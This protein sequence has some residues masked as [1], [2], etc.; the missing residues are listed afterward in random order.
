MRQ[1]RSTK[2]LSLLLSLTMVLGMFTGT[3]A[4]A[5]GD[6]ET[7]TYVLHPYGLKSGMEVTVPVGEE[8]VVSWEW[9]Q[10]ENGYIPYINDVR[11]NADRTFDAE[12][13]API[14]CG[15]VS[16]GLQKIRSVP[17][18]D[19][20]VLAPTAETTDEELDI[21]VETNSP[22]VP[23][24]IKYVDQ[25]GVE[26]ASVDKVATLFDS[27]YNVRASLKDIGEL[28]NVD[29][30]ELVKP[31][32][33]SINVTKD[34]DGNNV[35]IPDVVT[36]EVNV[37]RL[38]A[39]MDITIHYMD[40]Q[41]EVGT[42]TVTLE[43]G[44][45]ERTILPENLPDNYELSP[46]DQSAT[47]EYTADGKV[48]IN[49]AVV[50]AATASITFTVKKA[51]PPKAYYDIVVNGEK[52][53]T[54]GVG[55]GTSA[56]LQW[57]KY[58]PPHIDGQ[59]D[60]E[61]FN[62]LELVTA[63][64]TYYPTKLTELDGTVTNGF[65]F[66]E[67]VLR[68]Q[69]IDVTG[70]YNM[71]EEA[72]QVNLDLVINPM[73]V[74]LTAAE[75]DA[76]K[77]P[78]SAPK[79]IQ[80]QIAEDGTPQGS[81]TEE[82]P[83]LITTAAELDA[84]RDYSSTYSPKYFKIV[85]DID[86]SGYAE[87][88]TPIGENR[89]FRFGGIVDGNGKTI[90]GLNVDTGEEQYAGLFGYIDNA[91]ITNLTVEVEQVR[92][93]GYVGGLVG[94]A[95]DST[96]TGCG[97]RAASDDSIVAGTSSATGG[98]VGTAL[99]VTIKNSYT[100]VAVQGSTLV[101]GLV[102]SYSGDTSSYVENCYATGNIASTNTNPNTHIHVGGLIGNAQ[103][104]DIRNC[105]TTGDIQAT[106]IRIGGLTGTLASTSTSK[107]I[108]NSYAAG[109]ITAGEGSSFVGG[110]VGS[111]QTNGTLQNTYYN[112][113][114]GIAGCGTVSSDLEDTSAGKTEAELKSIAFALELDANTESKSSWAKWG[115]DSEI[116]GGYPVLCGIGIG[117][118]VEEVEEAPVVTGVTITHPNA[119]IEKGTTELFTATVE[120]EN[121]SQNVTWS[122]RG[123]NVSTIDA[124]GLL[125]V[126]ESEPYDIF[127]VRATSVDDPTKYAEVEVQLVPAGM[128]EG[129]GTEEDPYLITT[130]KELNAMRELSD[131]YRPKYFKIANDI[132]LSDYAETW[133]SIG[134]Y[135]REFGGIVDGNGKTIRG[136]K[137]DEADE[138]YVGLFAYLKNAVIK[139][140]TVE[141]EQVN[142]RVY[143][144]ALA[145]YANNTVID[146]C[147]VRAAS[148]ESS[149][150]GSSNVG[151]LVGTALRTTIT[152]SYAE[153]AVQGSTLVAGLVGSYSGDTSHYVENCYATG[154]VT[155]TNTDVDTHIHVGGLI[156]NAQKADI[157]NCF[158]AGNIQAT[159]KR[160][161]GL[162]GTL[163]G[164]SS[165]KGIKN[166][167]AAGTITAGEGSTWVGGLVGSFQTNGVLQDTYYNSD[168]GI[169]GCG[170]ASSK[171]EDTSTGKTGSELKSAAFALELDANTESNS[172]WAKWGLD[173]EINNGNPVLCG[174][175]IGKDVE[176]VEEMPVVTKITITHPNA[177]VEKGTTEPFTATVEGEN[178]SQNVTWSV[179]GSNVSTIDENGI[180][181]VPENEPNDILKVRATSVDD[182]TKY[183]EVEVQLVSAGMPEGS[184]TEA[185]PYLITTAKELDTMRKLSDTRSPKYFKIVNDIDVSDY[186]DT[187]TPIGNSSQEF[188]GIVDGNGK[189][190]RGLRVD[191]ADEMYVGLFA[192][193]RNSVIKNLTVE[194]EQ[195]N[196]RVDVGG[197]AGYAN[198]T[199]IDNCGVR[200]ASSES[201]IMGTSRVG[202]LVG[203]ASET[204][205][206]NSYAEVAVQGSTLV[207]GLVGSYSG[208]TSTYVE[209]CYATGDV[210]STNT[211]QKTH[212]EVGGLIGNAQKAD[213]RN[214]FATGDIQATGIRIGGLAGTF[215]GAD[216]DSGIKNSYAAGTITAG[217]GS[218]W[219]GG[220]VGSFQSKGTLQNAYYNS[221]NGLAG[222][223]AVFNN[224]ED[225]ST[226]KTEAE[227]KSDAFALELDTNTEPHSS[228]AKWG[229]D[230][231]IN[232]GYPVL[233]GIGIGA[234]VEEVEDEQ[235]VTF[236]SAG[237]GYL[238]DLTNMQTPVIET[239]A[240]GSEVPVPTTRPAN[241]YAF[242]HWTNSAGDRV[243]LGETVTVPFG[244]ETYT[245]HFEKYQYTRRFEITDPKYGTLTNKG[246]TGGAT[247]TQIDPQTVEV[248]GY[249]YSTGYY[250][251]VNV[252]DGYV[253]SGW[254]DKND[255]DGKIYKWTGTFKCNKDA[256]YEAVIVPKTTIQIEYQFVAEG[257]EKPIL[258]YSGKLT[259]NQ[260]KVLVSDRTIERLAEKGYRLDP[261]EQAEWEAL[262][263]DVGNITLGGKPV[264]WQGENTLITFTVVPNLPEGPQDISVS[265]GKNVKLTVDGESQLIADL[266]GK[267]QV[268]DVESGT[269][270][271]LTFTPKTKG[272]TFSSVKI[273]DAEP[274][275]ISGTT[276]TYEIKTPVAEADLSFTFEM[277]DKA[278]LQQA[279]DY[280]TT[281]VE[282]GT[283][284][285]LD[286][287]VRAAFMEAYQGAK[288]VL[289]NAKASQDDINEAWSELLDMIHYLG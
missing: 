275:Y 224:R 206:T 98:L 243:E 72:R 55:E 141:V 164:A 287:S 118:D 67:V 266:L 154:D 281:Y 83:Y 195:V 13:I 183:A 132:D 134:N 139:N 187:W 5:A 33:Q 261:A 262:Y 50:P 136:L 59:P 199:V 32:S 114:N 175:G 207:A 166:S 283:V 193:L 259:L 121:V 148:S 167:Y 16:G 2:I 36:F 54:L 109:T 233:C 159:G 285:Q 171:L 201:S 111:F 191:E 64:G 69:N 40:G 130:A 95:K 127:R 77:Y 24:T 82:D 106:G 9:D 4:F 289:D 68:A 58:T 239:G 112:S 61:P 17:A 231:E 18:E 133:T 189:T 192:Y 228:W 27:A 35:A 147:G 113:G 284:D 1:R 78:A 203:T 255:P 215:A 238:N 26:V 22:D 96:I 101:G 89:T 263:S 122:V 65:K 235:T 227:L 45:P 190:I 179:Q 277:T 124:D 60:K 223:G 211:E 8:A 200:A 88:W 185:D 144:G 126:P 174:I 226:G 150:V 123:S 249:D 219:V 240:V 245:A 163:A 76:E 252:A 62:R 181:T 278:I 57:K 43:K 85:N 138:M 90:R 216:T 212:V 102:G 129:S 209:N 237:G 14:E 81:G 177:K 31:T 25:D 3:T 30:I 23:Y 73:S 149:I 196:G 79:Q 173:E 274:V 46:A 15:K 204:T 202:G 87:T 198:D 244:G 250:P 194:V 180:L 254:R 119:K 264:E 217:E 247:S 246:G 269:V 75:G 253:W 268:K 286:E 93:K 145:G 66:N 242:S 37:V 115:L 42:D 19:A 221:G 165:S 155:S 178:V 170:S 52:A 186:A 116:N 156:G 160:I 282:D 38:E 152:N 103:K 63:K 143:V 120:G 128:P 131:T 230:A 29:D 21:L 142:G 34:E 51:A 125:T 273:G 49:G 257:V 28:E 105:F 218:T 20:Y 12:A 220:L 182:P 53:F 260:P 280:A 236:K 213:I 222:C 229:R 176:E 251:T 84:M 11:M 80:I 99:Y 270:I 39:T 117:E 44:A 108:K 157:R 272:Q 258:K 92:G 267:Y 107:G 256:T 158:A 104:A 91:T 205:I 248:M 225:T 10:E 140:L 184:G 6:G 151:G 146:N 288:D 74:D 47:A 265:Y 135:N 71:P 188:G 48:K 86:L 100:E 56:T 161:G 70:A 110:L 137:V 232:D 210:T 276:Y 234:D 41:T 271:T 241:G 172:S 97:V 94:Y 197:L 168:N 169:A 214:C 279:Y 162:T 7:Y 153:V 208:S